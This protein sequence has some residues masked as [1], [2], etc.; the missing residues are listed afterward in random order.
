MS[1]SA[2][3][4]VTPQ[5]KYA[6]HASDMSGVAGAA[7]SGTAMYPLY[8]LGQTAPDPNVWYRRPM[9]VLPVGV[10]LGVGIG[11]GIWGWFMPRLKKSVRKNMKRE[12]EEG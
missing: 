3:D 7:G 8:G 2:Q 5:A 11:W 12:R 10:A 4:F 6:E 1:K 9:F